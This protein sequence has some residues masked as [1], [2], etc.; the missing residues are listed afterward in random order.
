MDTPS[1]ETKKTIK[2]KKKPTSKQ[3]TFEKPVLNNPTK[4]KSIKIKKKK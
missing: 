2:V 4:P 3:D 1:K